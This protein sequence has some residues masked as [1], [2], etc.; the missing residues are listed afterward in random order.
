MSRMRKTKGLHVIVDLFGC[1][2]YQANSIKFWEDTLTYAAHS[3]NMEIL[4]QHFYQFKPHG[5]TGFLMLSTSHISVHTWPE[6]GYVACDVF[7]CSDD[8][9]TLK[10][11]DALTKAVESFRK[12]I[13]KIKRGYT[14][15]EYLES[16]V[17]RTGKI[18]RTRVIKKLAERV[19]SFQKIVVA[20]LKKFG[21]SLI[22]DGLVQTS[23]FD[24]D[25]Y[26]KAILSKLKPT[27]RHILILGGG[28]GYVAEMALKI[29]PDL[30]ITI[31]DLDVE[32]V[33][34]CKKY[35]HQAIFSHPNVQLNIGDA[36]SFLQ[37]YHSKGGE[38]VDGIVSDLTDNP[39]GVKGAKTKLK[40]FYEQIFTLSKKILKRD[41]W[42][43]VQAGASEVIPKYVDAAS[44]IQTLI[45]KIFGNYERKDVSVPSF[46][47]KNSF[48]FGTS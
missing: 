7:S 16:P 40:Y 27:D 32:V 25:I 48:I 19:S 24:H 11:V 45:A 28:D 21:K 8:T 38:P 18:V 23:E 29:N 33:N 3:A 22:I 47:E 37:T 44:M 39:I 6:Y 42:I 12:N 36:L 43:S 9:N 1:D 35:L 34:A 4:H 20:D 41:G 14:I 31:I 30:K 46:G 2:P 10:A 5:V 26:D 13:Q 17:Y 15:M